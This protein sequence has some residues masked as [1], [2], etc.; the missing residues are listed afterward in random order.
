VVEA[1]LEAVRPTA[2][3]KEVRLEAALEPGIW[4]TGDAHRLQQVVW[5]LLA[6][7]VKFTPAGGQ[8]AVTLG[9][10][11]THARIVVRDSG[12]G[13]PPDFLPHVFDRFRQ[14]DSSASRTYAGLGLGLAIVR[15]LVEGHGG[16]VCAESAGEGR[17]ANFTVTLPRLRAL[18][19]TAIKSEIPGRAGLPLLIGMRVLVVD[20]E[21]DARA[22]LAAAL[23]RCGAQVEV[24]A[25]AAEA[26][27]ALDRGRP[28]VLVS[29][30]GL[31]GEDGYALIRRVRSR[32]A[33][34]G[35]E[36][37]AVALTAYAS[38]EDAER[39]VVAGYQAHLPKPADVARLAQVVAELAG[40]PTA[41]SAK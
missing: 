6:N 22:A 35:G 10:A 39:A 30:I 41:G 40:R 26:L 19:Q 7:A 15:H 23:G 14:A 2:E 25:S 16:T 17:G 3:A 28:H 20:D 1:A 32:A 12:Q 33:A 5:N 8:V 37:P 29:D 31:P 4:V 11:D 36:V 21:D 34:A 24:A 13:I 18:A 38:R 27:I 9:G